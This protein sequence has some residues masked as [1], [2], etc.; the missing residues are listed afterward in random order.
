MWFET[1]SSVVLVFAAIV[2]ASSKIRTVLLACGYRALQV[3][4]VG[5]V[6]AAGLFSVYSPNGLA[7]V[8]ECLAAAPL[9]SWA[10]TP[11]GWPEGAV[12]LLRGLILGGIAAV[13]L[14]LA[15]FLRD[16]ASIRA[17]YEA[18][19]G[20]LQLANAEIHESIQQGGGA[21]AGGRRLGDI[22]AAVD[23][24]RHLLK[25]G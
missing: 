24:I 1:L 13:V 3:A 18:I 7:G 14:T 20:E 22:G 8:G 23:Q 25:R 12:W 15:Q 21:G 19:R 16:V 17:T 9:L 5:S 2:V 11:E 4:L 6:L 10:T